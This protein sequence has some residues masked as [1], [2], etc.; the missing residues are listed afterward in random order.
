MDARR[1]LNFG[2]YFPLRAV[3]SIIQ[4]DGHVD[5]HPID[6]SHGAP[7]GPAGTGMRSVL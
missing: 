7:S 5:D 3:Y 1:G 2:I 6:R 4:H